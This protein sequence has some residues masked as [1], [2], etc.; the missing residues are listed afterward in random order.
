MIVPAERNFLRIAS[1]FIAILGLVTAIYEIANNQN[2]V[3]GFFAATTALY[4]GIY[5]VQHYD[6]F[7]PGGKE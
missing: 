6:E 3:A 7:D 2:P 5:F 1:F 4:A